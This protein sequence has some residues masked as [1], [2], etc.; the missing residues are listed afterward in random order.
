MLSEPRSGQWTPDIYHYLH[1]LA[2]DLMGNASLHA[3][4]V[5]VDRSIVFIWAASFTEAVHW[6]NIEGGALTGLPT[7]AAHRVRHFLALAAVGLLCRLPA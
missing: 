1:A 7:C 5:V 4:C 2:T 3:K 6:R